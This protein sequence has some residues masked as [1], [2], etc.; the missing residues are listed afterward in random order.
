MVLARLLSPAD[1]GLIAIA[2]VLIQ[3]VEAIYLMHADTKQAARI[4][5]NVPRPLM[6]R[7]ALLKPTAITQGTR[8]HR[9]CPSDIKLNQAHSKQLR[10]LGSAIL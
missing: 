6:N 8:D 9:V 3:V 1:F 2:M 5:W 10:N 4:A 7:R